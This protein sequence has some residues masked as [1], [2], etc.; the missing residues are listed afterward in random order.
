MGGGGAPTILGFF[1]DSCDADTVRLFSPFPLL[2]R[3]LDIMREVTAS[4]RFGYVRERE[5]ERE[6][7]RRAR[8][9]PAP[10]RGLYTNPKWKKKKKR[11]H[12][13]SSTSDH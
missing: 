7:E 12:S 6:R 11:I 10:G 5:R 1:S 8:A 3:P 9:G 13:T 4:G 2:G